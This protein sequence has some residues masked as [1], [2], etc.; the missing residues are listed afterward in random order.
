VQNAGKSGVE[1]GKLIA[2]LGTL[3]GSRHFTGG[4]VGAKASTKNKKRWQ[5]VM[6]NSIILFGPTPGTAWDPSSRIPTAKVG[7]KKTTT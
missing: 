5:K 1:K 2:T 3:L 6:T 7:K 4:D